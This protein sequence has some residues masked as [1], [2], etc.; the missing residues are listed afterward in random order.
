[1]EGALKKT[2]NKKKTTPKHYP[3]CICIL[4]FQFL[5]FK[6]AWREYNHGG[7]TKQLNQNLQAEADNFISN[8]N[9]FLP[10]YL[11]CGPILVAKSCNHPGQQIG[12]LAVQPLSFSY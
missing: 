7:N 8:L 12:G 9:F 10:V 3:F 2:K 1:M 11:L 5:A 4:K 6:T